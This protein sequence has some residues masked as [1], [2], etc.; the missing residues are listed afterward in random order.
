MA[1]LPGKSARCKQASVTAI[2]FM[3]IPG[4]FI[5]IAKITKDFVSMP[6]SELPTMS[7]VSGM[8]VTIIKYQYDSGEHFV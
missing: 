8:C 5:I 2:P 6:Y 7:E 1:T 3:R 4:T